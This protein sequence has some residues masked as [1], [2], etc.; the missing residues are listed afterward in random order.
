MDTLT[1]QR[2]EKWLQEP[3]DLETRSQ[4]QMLLSSGGKELEDS[5]YKELSFG[6]GGLRGLMGVGTNR[7][8][9]YTVRR[10]TQ[11]LGNYLKK[12]MKQQNL[13][14][15]IGFDNRLLSREFANEA[16]SVLIQNG[17]HV[18]FL[19]NLRPTPY[20]SFACRHF[21]ASAAIMITASHNPKEYNG[22]KV[23]WQD[24]AQ[25]V[26][27]HDEG[28]IQ[29]ISKIDNF[30]L[31]QGHSPGTL[32]LIGD[33]LDISYV[34]AIRPLQNFP[35]ENK[36]FGNELQITYTSLHGTGITIV[37]MVLV[38]W[39]FTSLHFVYKQIVP[40][41]TFPTVKVPNPE[42]KE[43]LQLGLDLMESSSSDLLL[44]TDPDADRLGVAVQHRGKPVILNGNE[45]A[46][47]CTEYL[48]SI[49]S[50]KKEL[51]LRSAIITTIVSTDLIK[52]ICAAYNVECHLV[53]TG[54]KYIGEKIHL[55][56]TE[57]FSPSFL[58][59]AEESYGY[60][61]GTQARDKDAIIM[62]CLLAEI[63]L[64]C[65]KL[66][67]TLVDFLYEIYQKHGIFRESLISIEFAPGKEGSDSIANLMNRLRKKP[68]QEIGGIKV[69]Q[70][71]DYLEK[72]LTGLPESDV[73]VLRLEDE[74]KL[75]V[76]PSGTEPKLK[77]YAGTRCQSFTDLE[78]GIEAADTKLTNLLN[79]LK[80]ELLTP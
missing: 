26:S 20:I 44:A 4:V 5:F 45:T 59:G 52:T 23:Y 46:S 70:I 6:T 60:L 77:I 33:E 29:E 30:D 11:G 50:S 67:K 19:K 73:L 3:F 76:R 32:H 28:I 12:E 15:V 27:P 18:F 69:L 57:P 22:Y 56:E 62:S 48:C 39:G 80:K 68:L 47:I 16:A 49:L 7:M 54:F 36:S 40:D 51:P 31:P 75:I 43:A 1:K 78:K 14:V 2:I 9:R 24:G 25:V 53:L 42:Y 35:S 10:S 34:D 13:S 63:A 79:S 21:G 41:G 38:D 55:W 65:K 72:H 61:Y 8:N 74:S 37:P 58:F 71:E 17:I 66:G 64:H